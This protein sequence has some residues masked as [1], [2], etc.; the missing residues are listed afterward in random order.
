MTIKSLLLAGILAL[1]SLTTVYAKSYQIEL[2]APMKAGKV[3]LKPGLYTLAVDGSNAT[4]T[5][6]RREALTTPV[7]VE[8][9][10]KKYKVTIVDSAADEIRYIELGGSTTRL[11]FIE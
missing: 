8:N 9:G 7:K 10:A 5:N 6:Q 4:F 2:H 1:S 3:Q 11:N